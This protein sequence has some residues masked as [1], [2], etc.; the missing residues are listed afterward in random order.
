[1]NRNAIALW[2]CFSRRLHCSGFPILMGMYYDAR[3]SQPKRL[4]EPLPRKRPMSPDCG[5]RSS[6][7]KGRIN[8][9]HIVSEYVTNNRA[10]CNDELGWFRRQRSLSSAIRFAGL[11]M[12]HNKK[13][14]H[15][16]R[17]SRTALHTACNVLL[18]HERE[19][20]RCESFDELHALLNTLLQGTEGVGELYIYDTASRIGARLDLWPTKVYLHAGTREGARALGFD[21]RPSI[22][23]AD[24]RKE[25]RRL[26]PYEIEDFLCICKDELLSLRRAR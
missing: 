8:L 21:G 12:V 11:A 14:P 18:G 20:R 6:R 23:V 7:S 1:M 24:L 22:E 5:T 19:I 2:S 13:H 10:R 17:L 9:G 4:Q 25:L 16:H 26:K 3:S 15:Q